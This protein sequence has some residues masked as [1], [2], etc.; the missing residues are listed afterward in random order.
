MLTYQRLIKKF[1]IFLAIFLIINIIIILLYAFSGIL[2]LNNQNDLSVNKP[3]I[4]NK[5]IITISLV[6]NGF[7]KYMV[8]T[9]VGI[10]I[11]IGLEKYEPIEIKN[12]MDGKNKKNTKKIAPPEGLYLKDVKYR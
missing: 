11:Q 6:S 7:L 1:G 12:I 9:I 3:L 5:D 2:N 10:L 4:V 8:R